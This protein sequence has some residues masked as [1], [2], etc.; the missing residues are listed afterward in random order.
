MPDSIGDDGPVFDS[1]VD[2]FDKPNMLQMYRGLE[3]N[4]YWQVSPFTGDN[5]FF[6]YRNNAMQGFGDSD[7]VLYMHDNVDS[8]V[9]MA[10]SNYRAALPSF[11][12][13]M[14]GGGNNV[15]NTNRFS[16]LPM[17]KVFGSPTTK[18]R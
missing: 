2:Q 8:D 17:P 11:Y 12:G 13:N 10:F 5:R 3:Y 15:P 9:Y 4:N 16:I 7:F 14:L 18:P 6:V 1:Y